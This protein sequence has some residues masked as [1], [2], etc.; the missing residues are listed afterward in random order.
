MQ[1]LGDILAGFDDAHE[2]NYLAL[3]EDRR[4][5]RCR[6]STAGLSGRIPGHS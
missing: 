1:I 4:R 3:S 5:P 6:K 2:I